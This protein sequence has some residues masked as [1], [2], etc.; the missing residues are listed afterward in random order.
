M[1]PFREEIIDEQTKPA[2][3]PKTVLN[4]LKSIQIESRH[5]TSSTNY[6]YRRDNLEELQLSR[7]K[8]TKIL[9]SFLYSNSNMKN[10]CL[11]NGSFRELVPLERLAKIESLGVVP[12]LK[13]LKLTDLPYHTHH[14]HTHIKSPFSW[15]S[16]LE[17]PFLALLLV[18]L[19]PYEVIRFSISQEQV[20]RNH[21]IKSQLAVTCS[22]SNGVRAFAKRRHCDHSDERGR[23]TW[24]HRW[25]GGACGIG[26][27]RCVHACGRG[28][29]MRACGGG[30]QQRHVVI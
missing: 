7:L 23:C 16:E 13:S 11:N 4:N 18:I 30:R 6:D 21:L 3:F 5:A 29:A 24:V 2:L 10:L 22:N 19:S 1:K 8:D 12:H 26:R 17:L 27:G 28:M 25:E 15:S 14:T 9:Y 20:Y